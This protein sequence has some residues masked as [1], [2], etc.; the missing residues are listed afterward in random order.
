MIPRELKELNQWVCCS[1][2]NK[3][4]M[5]A[6]E[7]KAAS[8]SDPS[9]WASYDTALESVAD[10]NYEY[11]G[12]VFNDNGIVGIDIDIGFE[13]EQ[14]IV[15]NEMTYDIITKCHSY[16][17]LSKSGRGFHIFVKGDLPFSGK[18]NR[19]GLEIYKDSRFFVMTGKTRYYTEL[20]ENQD[21]IDYVLLKYFG[22]KERPRNTSR[23]IKQR[24][25]EPI[26]TTKVVNG[27][28]VITTEYPHIQEGN[29]NNSLLSLGGQLLAAGM[30]QGEIYQEL[31]RINSSKV[32]PPLSERELQNVVRS[33]EKYRGRN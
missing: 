20:V 19:E 15:L 16:T 31:S 3:I 7:P 32:H 5:K 17:E 9:T 12:F 10:G 2:A 18:N 29:R 8:S 21:A 26:Q 27:K 13:D 6:T 28:I 30:S 11:L 33:V 23:I 22:E 4:P 1:K 24:I 14:N 25:Y